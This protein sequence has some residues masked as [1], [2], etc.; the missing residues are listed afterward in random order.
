MVNP[1]KIE[2][3]LLSHN[4]C[5]ICK[6]FL[7]LWDITLYELITLKISKSSKEIPYM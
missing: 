5:V 4:S 7:K 6:M 1:F 3:G 2:Y